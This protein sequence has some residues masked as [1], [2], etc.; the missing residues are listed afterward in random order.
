MRQDNT[1][2]KVLIKKY[3]SSRYIYIYIYIDRNKQGL[4]RTSFNETR[5]YN[6]HIFDKNIFLNLRLK[7][8]TRQLEATETNK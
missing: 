8:R 7:Y 5:Q 6:I 2:Y 1:I 3:V 4:K